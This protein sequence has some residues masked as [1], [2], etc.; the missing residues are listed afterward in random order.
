MLKM[1]KKYKSIPLRNLVPHENAC[2]PDIR[3]ICTYCY[4]C[5]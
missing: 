4:F 3:Y 5:H 2:E 1:P